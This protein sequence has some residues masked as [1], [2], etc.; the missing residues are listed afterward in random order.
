MAYA[1]RPPQTGLMGDHLTIM[2]NMPSMPSL[3]SMQGSSDP[4]AEMAVTPD[5]RGRGPGKKED[6]IPQWGYHETKEFIAIRA[7]L[8][9]DFTQTKRNKTLWELIS[10]KMKEKS[11]RRSADQCKCKWKNLVNRYKGKETSEPDN[12][13]QC[14]FFDELHTIFIER[15]K[16]MDRLYLESEPGLRPKKKVKRGELKLYDE[17][18]EEEDETKEDNED[19]RLQR[20]KKRKSDKER[21]R[22]TADKYRANSMQEV[23][24]DFSQQQLK[25]EA[26]WREVLDKR[27]LERR[28]KEQEWQKNMEYLEHDRIA[29]EHA[30]RERE[31]EWREREEA[32]AEKR[33]ELFA[34]LFSK[35]A[36]RINRR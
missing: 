32:R 27:E 30:W 5:G 31:E 8:E 11:Y 36:Q 17:D 20:R 22:V 34:Q 35:Y 3:S 21:Q 6:R 1:M 18:T 25:A 9:K 15:A 19:E 29:R 7:E 26:I 4:G 10:G 23:L 14:P 2:T 28:F 16:N 33:D 13:R 12:G 24:E